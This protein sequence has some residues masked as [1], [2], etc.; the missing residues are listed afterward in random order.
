MRHN[1]SIRSHI[2]R[3][4]IKAVG[5]ILDHKGIAFL[6]GPT[7][8]DVS[9]VVRV[10]RAKVEIRSAAGVVGIRDGPGPVTRHQA[11]AD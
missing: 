8:D 1:H 5:A 2:P 3:S 11:K 6:D 7:S 10:K 9:W 4:S